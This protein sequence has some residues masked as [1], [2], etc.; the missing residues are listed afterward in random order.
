MLAERNASDCH[1]EDRTMLD[2]LIVG[3]GLCGLSIANRLQSAGRDYLLV[4]ARPRAGG[5][6]ETVPA[7]ASAVALDLGPGWYW[8]QTQPRM[9]KLLAE[10]KLQSHPQHDSGVILHLAG[11]DASPEALAQDGVHNGAHRVAGGMG[12]I[13]AALMQRLAPDRLRAG[14]TLL[15]LVDRGDC[16]EAH[17]RS[18][19]EDFII[20]ARHVVLAM[21]PRLIAERIAFEPALDAPLMQA[22]QDTPT[23]MSAQAK[24]AM[25]YDQAFWRD[26]GLSGNAFVS[27]PQAVLAEV[28]DACDHAGSQAAIGGFIA[29]SPAQRKLYSASLALLVRSQLAQLFGPQADAGE[30][31]LRNWASEPLTCSERD[32]AAPS[33]HPEDGCA[34]LAA[35]CWDGRLLLGGS[36]TAT[37]GAGYL[38]GALDA[39]ARVSNRLL[40]RSAAARMPH[41]PLN[42]ASLRRFSAW[43]FEQRRIC[44]ALYR[45]RA[46]QALTAQQSIGLTRSVLLEVIDQLYA[47]A[48]AELATLSFDT[49]GVAVDQGRSALTPDVLAPFSGLSDELLGE[50]LKHNGTSCAMSNFPDEHQP[51]AH[52]VQQIRRDLALAWRAFAL[53]ANALLLDKAV[54]AKVLH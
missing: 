47:D 13:V 9:V 6:I 48:L 21:P 26:A 27:H 14:C 15:R 28:F 29:L 34:V 45:Q 19:Q 16:V 52:Y 42:D 18:P 41:S 53:S 38:E 20:A 1:P 36:E 12:A 17:C 33:Q 37:R 44:A 43:L 5:R 11:S 46:A 50:A 24:V 25:R 39:A 49:R 10:L 23:W 8:P 4:D 31:H 35:D 3:A 54:D 22:L 40:A 7:T 30:L 2:T 51:S 32:A